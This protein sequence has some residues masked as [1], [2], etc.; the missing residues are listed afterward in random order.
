MLARL[1]PRLN[2]ATVVGYLALFVALGGGALAATSFVG[3][4]GQ[5]H[6]CVSKKGQLTVLKPGKKCGK[7]K[8]SLA[9]GE[10]GPAGQNGRD[11]TP[12]TP[13]TPGKDLTVGSTLP[14]GQTESGIFA[15][16][17][18]VASGFGSDAIEFR[19]PLGSGLANANLHD[20][21]SGSTAD[22]PG[23][24]QAAR[25]H[26]CLYEG[27]NSSMSFLGF[28]NPTTGSGGTAAPGGV[29]AFFTAGGTQSHVRGTWSVTAP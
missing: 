26:L 17:A 28:Y 4:D 16:T 13:G 15:A 18:N 14:S 10:K 29:V 11:G 23:R 8:T 5:I 3:G 19:P 22:C 6:G 21:T 2:H 25:G 1:R 9:W 20:L 27:S 24:G 7:G 12:G